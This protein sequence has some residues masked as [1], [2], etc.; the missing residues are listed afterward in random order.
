MRGVA[1]VS[2]RITF[3][4]KDAGEDK[5]TANMSEQEP[6]RAAGSCPCQTEPAFVSV[7]KGRIE[8]A[9]D[10]RWKPEERFRLWSLS[11]ARARAWASATTVTALVQTNTNLPVHAGTR[12]LR[13]EG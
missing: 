1:T 2:G 12:S 8:R 13:M 9:C 6:R 3:T 5:D 4:G 7:S 10:G 11:Q